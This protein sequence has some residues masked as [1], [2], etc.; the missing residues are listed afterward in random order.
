MWWCAI[1]G[2]MLLLVAAWAGL[3]VTY[4]DARK[5]WHRSRDTAVRAAR[6]S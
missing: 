4:Y 5:A 2:L 3:Y 6:L 1:A